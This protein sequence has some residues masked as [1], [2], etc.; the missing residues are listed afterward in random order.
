MNIENISRS[1]SWKKKKLIKRKC[2]Q[3]TSIKMYI[4]VSSNITLIKNFS[5][6]ITLV[7]NVSR[8]R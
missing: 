1:V 8:K 2:Q 7:K 3:E 6:N 5:S 4:N